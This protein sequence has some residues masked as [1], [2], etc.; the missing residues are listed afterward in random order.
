MDAASGY[1]SYHQTQ[2]ALTA[3]QAAEY[4]QQAKSQEELILSF[5]QS[6]PGVAMSPEYIRD[7]ILPQAPL[8]SVRRAITNLTKAGELVHTDEVVAGYYGR[9]VGTWK[10]ASKE[11]RQ[12][13]L[14]SQ[15]LVK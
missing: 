13:G 5:F 7:S 2:S 11:V 15:G 6:R 14:F 4:R 8:T 1:R 10:A 3:S 12:L 9:P